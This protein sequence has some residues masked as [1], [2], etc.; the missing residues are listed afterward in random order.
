MKERR[1][2]RREEGKVDEVKCVKYVVT[3][4]KLTVGGEYNAIDI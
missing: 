1:E 2:G 4:R 3:E